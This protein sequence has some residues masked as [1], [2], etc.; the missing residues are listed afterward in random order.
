MSLAGSAVV[1]I[2]N[3]VT[4]AGRAN[5][6][7]WHNREHI[8][9]RVAIDG[10]LRGRR[11]ITEDGA[12]EYFTLYEV[13]DDSVLGGPGYLSRLNAPTPWTTR[14]VSYFRNVARSLCRIDLSHG[15]ASGGVLGTV[16]FDCPDTQDDGLMQRLAAVLA[17]LAAA[18][19][20]VAHHVCRADIAVS[21]AKT[22]EQEGRPDNAVPRWVVLIEGSTTEAVRAALAGALAPD[23]LASFQV[24]DFASGTYILQFDLLSG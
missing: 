5:F 23:A 21:T 17:E 22:A 2:W 11:Y 10:F 19:G 7:E 15:A 16:R 14:S 3:D 20:I 18:P 8:P 13:R 12:P 24:T 9:E 1:A 4:E 6:Y